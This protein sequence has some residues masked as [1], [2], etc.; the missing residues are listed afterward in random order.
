VV[1]AFDTLRSP[2]ELW[3]RDLAGGSARAITHFND[4][5]V[6]AARMGEYEQFSF[7]GAAGET[8]HGY[9]VKP[10]DFEPSRRYPVAFLIHGGPQGSFGDH[11]HYRWNP[12][13]FAGAGY[14]ALMIDFHGSTGYGQAFTD[15]ING[16]WGGA[17]FEDLM[18][19]LDFALA[20]YPFLDGERV[21][22]LGASFGGYMVNWI[23]GRTE[24]FR[25]LVN[26]DGNLDER[27]AYFDTEELWFP[28]WELGRP[29]EDRAQYDRW[30][31]HLHVHRWQT[32]T[33]VTHG[34]LDYRV[35]VNHAHA[36]FTALQRRGVPSKLLVFPDE[37]HHVLKPRNARAF[38]EVVFGWIREHLGGPPPAAPPA[39]TAR[40]AP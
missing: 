33:L 38:H 5:R 7:A 14:A 26:H 6:A 20:K 30:S 15:S 11:F 21:G 40:A 2:V 9:L 13:I 34:E 23:A 17:P 16:D 29:W 22:A 18:K 3:I 32:P 37:G 28:E 35:T 8:V 25:C 4:A 24:R 1:Y 10:V 27:M 12:E 39:P 19:G 36:A 31:P